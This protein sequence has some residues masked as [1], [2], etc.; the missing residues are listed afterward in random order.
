[1]MGF[2]RYLVVGDEMENVHDTHLSVMLT[3]STIP[4]PAA[5]AWGTGWV[6]YA[7]PMLGENDVQCN[8]Y[9]STE[10]AK[11]LISCV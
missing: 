10:V 7:M 2:N 8:R 1:M 9:K 4:G 5:Y 11:C 6:H 3:Q